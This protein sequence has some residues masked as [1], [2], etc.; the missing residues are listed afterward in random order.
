[1]DVENPPIPLS[2]RLA[3]YKNVFYIG[4]FCLLLLT[5]LAVKMGGKRHKNE[6]DFVMAANAFTKWEQAL[7]KEHYALTN[8]T[9]LMKKHPELH[10]EYGAKLAQ[11]FIAIEDELEA[12][13]FGNQV[14]DRT[15]Q[16][17]YKDYAR[18]SLLVSERKFSKALEE[19]LRLKNEMLGDK[20]FW[21]KSQGVKSFG[22]ALFAFNLMRIATLFQELGSKEQELEAWKELKSYAGWEGSQKDTRVS[23]EGFESLLNHFSVRDMTLLDYIAAREG[24]LSN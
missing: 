18:G 17:Y 5:F 9:R 16:P 1:M 24:E 6:V 12:R 21:K 8:L 22:S 23:Q 20:D 2:L 7:D 19:A 13:A 15:N 4:A 10:A 3:P 14:I 11:T